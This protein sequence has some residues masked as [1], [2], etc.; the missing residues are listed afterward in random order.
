MPEPAPQE[1][2]QFL[3]NIQRLL[4][5]GLFVASYKFALLLALADLSIDK[6]D[7]SGA[8]LSLSGRE[9]AEKLIQYYW[10]QAVPYPSADA[11]RI[12]QQ[13]T[14]RQAAILNMLRDVRAAHGNSLAAVEQNHTIWADMVRR[15]AELVRIMP[16]WKLQ[17][18]GSE[19]V[20]FLYK[21]IGT[22]RSI[23]LRP[24][25]AYCFRKFH[26]LISD[27]VRGAWARYVRQQNPDLLG[28]ATD[29]NG[30]LFGSE[31][32]SLAAVRPVLMDVQ[33]GR[34]FY[35]RSPLTNANT[36]VDH[37]VAWSRYP[38]D[39]GHNFVLA[40]NKCNLQ[41]R[42]RLPACEHLALWT[43]RNAQ[44]SG[45]IAAALTEAGIV[46][47]LDTSNRVV[48]WAYSQTEAA[49]GLTWL[50]ADEMVPLAA[51][52]RELMRLDSS[53]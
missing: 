10:R 48:Q 50:R 52:W 37:F 16:L 42:E 12:L 14:G 28:E 29:L 30:F 5:E 2:I 1:Q 13:N 49:S 23:E 35:C 47:D 4:D 26:V 53:A 8:P 24:G 46:T 38:V 41:K 20:D 9:I 18:V 44:F 51:R 31:R 17:T 40:D 6:G 45:Q 32:I 11:P 43:E 7:D 21:N 27:L 3:I 36:H 22:G 19:R 15:V 33:Q 34:C 25:V 39:L